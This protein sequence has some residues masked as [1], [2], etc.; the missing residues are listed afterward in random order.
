M[1]FHDSE[2]MRFEREEVKALNVI[3][4]EMDNHPQGSG[5]T[6]HKERFF[7]ERLTKS[8]HGWVK[9]PV[10]KTVII[11]KKHSYYNRY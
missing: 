10:G 7:L 4:V 1:Y 8:L 2:A 11:R 3:G 9:H 6:Q 5:R